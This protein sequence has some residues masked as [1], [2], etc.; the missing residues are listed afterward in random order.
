MHLQWVHWSKRTFWIAGMA[1]HGKSWVSLLGCIRW[2]GGGSLLL[3]ICFLALLGVACDTNSIGDQN[4]R[5]LAR[6]KK[7]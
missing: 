2:S 1:L 5:K 3:G 4:F 7:K 6:K